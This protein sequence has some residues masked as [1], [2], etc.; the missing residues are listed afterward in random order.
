MSVGLRARRAVLQ[1]LSLVFA[2]ASLVAC[3]GGGGSSAPSAPPVPERAPSADAR[4]AA[5]I[6]ADARLPQVRAKARALIAKGLNAGSGYAEVYI[7]DFNTFMD[8]AVEALGAAPVRAQLRI[9]L[10]RQGTDGNIADAFTVPDDA[11]L[12]NNV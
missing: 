10:E 6:R 3:S 11:I 1:R 5:T 7:R 8:L 9:F 12:K 4:L 2:A